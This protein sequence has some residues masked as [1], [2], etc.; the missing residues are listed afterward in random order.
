MEF[1]QLNGY[2]DRY[3]SKCI[4]ETKEILAT[5]VFL[6]ALSFAFPRSTRNA[7]V[8]QLARSV[9]AT[10]GK[11]I[12]ETASGA[13]PEKIRWRRLVL[14]MTNGLLQKIVLALARIFCS[15]GKCRHL[16]AQPS[17]SKI[18]GVT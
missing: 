13:V 16:I 14:A 9:Y 3:M 15:T 12:V 5:V 2:S 1:F 10:I 7:L 6:I 8:H 4:Q 11:S 17:F 18:D